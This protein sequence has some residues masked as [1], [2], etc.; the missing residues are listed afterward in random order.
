MDRNTENYIRY[1]NYVIENMN[2]LKTSGSNLVLSKIKDEID[3]T[4]LELKDVRRLC[5]LVE[6][7]KISENVKKLALYHEWYRYFR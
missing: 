1:Y 3:A 6:F 2:L 5:E 7:I 4:K